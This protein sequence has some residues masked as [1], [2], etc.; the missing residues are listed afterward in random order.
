MVSKLGIGLRPIEYRPT[1]VTRV[2]SWSVCVCV[3]I[4]PPRARY[5]YNV[6][7]I[8]VYSATYAYIILYSLLTVIIAQIPTELGVSAINHLFADTII[9][10]IYAQCMHIITIN[11][12]SI[13]H[14]KNK[15][16]ACTRRLKKKKKGMNITNL[17][18]CGYN[19]IFMA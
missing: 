10:Y 4:R 6:V 7:C 15:K 19:Y 12:I 2:S 8:C 1:N 14:Y 3:C 5:V 18:M 13:K 11:M 9:V 16:Y 17:K